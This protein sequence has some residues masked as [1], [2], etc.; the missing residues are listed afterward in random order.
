[1]GVAAFVVAVFSAVCSA[2]AAYCAWVGNKAAGHANN[3]AERAEEIAVEANKAAV[4]ANQIAADANIIS[5]RALAVSGDKIVYQWRVRCD[6]VQGCF[7][8]VNDSAH[9]ANNV[10][11]VVRKGDQ[12]TVACGRFEEVAEFGEVL[13]PAGD[14]CAELVEKESE[15]AGALGWSV[16]Q[17]HRV[18]V[19]AHIG[20]CSE[21]GVL[22]DCV[23]DECVC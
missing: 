22:R 16:A 11:V 6:V 14:F 17:S 12:V 2:V 15:V 8:V 13:L 21:F 3:L 4:E 10:R 9:V 19:V 7:V 1:M 20:W 5:E 18:D 23:V